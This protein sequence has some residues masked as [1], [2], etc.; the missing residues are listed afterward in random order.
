MEVPW[1]DNKEETEDKIVQRYSTR[2]RVW[3]GEGLLKFGLFVYKSLLVTTLRD[4][5]QRA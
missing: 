3:F 4:G 2:E 1:E 5:G